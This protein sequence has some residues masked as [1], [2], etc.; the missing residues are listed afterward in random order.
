MTAVATEPHTTFWQVEGQSPD[1]SW[2]MVYCSDDEGAMRRALE[3]ALDADDD[4]HNRYEDYRLVSPVAPRKHK[5]HNVLE[6]GHKKTR[7]RATAKAAAK[8]SKG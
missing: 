2:H 6:T 5:A 3:F 1:G 7:R 8:K 4:V